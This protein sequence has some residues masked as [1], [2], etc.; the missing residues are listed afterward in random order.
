MVRN[1]G[2]CHAMT[3]YCPITGEV[4]PNP[5]QTVALSA[6]QKLRA[7]TNN[8]TGLMS[9]LDA[10]LAGAGRPT[11]EHVR[12]MPGS[13]PPLSLGFLTLIDEHRDTLEAWAWEI[14]QHIN[15]SWRMLDHTWAR[16]QAIYQQK[17]LDLTTWEYA[18]TMIDEVTDA[19]GY[20]KRAA[21][22]VEPVTYTNTTIEDLPDKWLTIGPAAT[23]IFHLTGK[24]LPKQ[25]I[26]SWE[27]RGKIESKGDPKRYSMRDLLALASA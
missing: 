17:L 26:Y 2:E 9:D 19:L 15:P 16:V 4:L 10:R 18:P 27:R 11:G 6:L 25:T 22:Y 8:L 20:L 13:Q 5:G 12:T 7:E 21:G 23:A 24:P 1:K 14:M 3:T